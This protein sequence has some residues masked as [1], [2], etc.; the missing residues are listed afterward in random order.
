M[1]S[2]ALSGRTPVSA[3]PRTTRF[4]VPGHSRGTLAGKF[5]SGQEYARLLGGDAEAGSLESDLAQAFHSNETEKSERV[6]APAAGA[7]EGAA[8]PCRAMRPDTLPD[9][10]GLVPRPRVIGPL[11]GGRR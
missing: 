11:I 1:G 2:G 7:S 5:E 9:F 10:R 6:P 8:G 4:L 3:P